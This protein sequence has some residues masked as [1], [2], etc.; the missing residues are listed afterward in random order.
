MNLIFAGNERRFA[1]YSTTTYEPDENDDEVVK[2]TNE[3][4]LNG[5]IP[6]SFDA[7]EWSDVM[8]YYKLE[9]GEIVFDESYNPPKP[10]GEN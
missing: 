1:G 2:K 6:D 10:T 9:N 7:E 8:R 5:L 3:E 4:N